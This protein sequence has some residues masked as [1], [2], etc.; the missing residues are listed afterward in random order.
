MW[1]TPESEIFYGLFVTIGSVRLA[2]V[3]F[4][5]VASAIS[6]DNWYN[7]YNDFSFLVGKAEPVFNMSQLDHQEYA[8]LYFHQQLL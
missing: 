6:R 4:T 5:R 3:T 7:S 1:I 8:F 2:E